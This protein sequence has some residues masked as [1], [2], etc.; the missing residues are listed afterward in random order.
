MHICCAPA[1]S[2]RCASCAPPGW[3]SPAFSTAHNIHPYSECRRR[4]ETLPGLR[5]PDRP[6]DHLAARATTWR[7]SSARWCTGRKSAG[8][9]CYQQRL[10]AT[11]APG[12]RGHYDAYSTTLL[13]SAIR[14]TTPSGTWANPS[15]ARWGSPFTTVTSGRAGSKASRKSRRIGLYRQKYCGCIYSEKERFFRE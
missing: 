11:A 12:T 3:R 5:P 6:R 13:Y 8:R 1:R 10:Q 4:Q 7:V 9:I 14:S 15:D 2:S